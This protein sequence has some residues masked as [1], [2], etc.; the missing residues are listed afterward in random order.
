MSELYSS[1]KLLDS[2]ASMPHRQNVGDIGYD[3]SLIERARVD[4][5]RWGPNIQVYRTGI[6]IQPAGNLYWEIIPRSSLSK[7]AYIMPHSV[8]II[9]QGYTGE[10]LVVLRKVDLER[11]DLSLPCRIVQLVPRQKLDVKFLLEE[12]GETS[13]AD[14]GFGSTGK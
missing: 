1:I 2:R 10:I 13:R 5:S 6:K 9:D 4:S 14:G 11:E 12:I 8:G 3:V 7:T